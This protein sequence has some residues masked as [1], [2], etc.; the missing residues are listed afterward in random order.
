VARTYDQ[1]D[2]KTPRR[3]MNYKAEGKRRVGGPKIR[4]NDTVN[5]GIRRQVLK[6]VDRS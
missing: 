6:T 2:S 4:G 1:N 3:I 5:T